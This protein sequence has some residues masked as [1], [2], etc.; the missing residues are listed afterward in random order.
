MG[1]Q[2]RAPQIVCRLL[3]NWLKVLRVNSGHLFLCDE[4]GVEPFFTHSLPLLSTHHELFIIR[5]I[6]VARPFFHFSFHSLAF[7]SVSEAC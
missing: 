1:R 6:I 2:P 7:W 5:L 3:F 4:H